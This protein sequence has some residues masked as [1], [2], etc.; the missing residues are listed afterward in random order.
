MGLQNFWKHKVKVICGQV[1]IQMVIVLLYVN[2][3][4]KYL[5]VAHFKIS[6]S[7]FKIVTSIQGKISCKLIHKTW[8]L[9]LGSRAYRSQ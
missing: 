2:P 3:V 9:P 7:S 4:L 6:D 1:Q 5:F 8:S